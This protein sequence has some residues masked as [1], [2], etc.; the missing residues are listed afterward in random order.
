M[1]YADGLAKVLDSV[2]IEYVYHKHTSNC[3]SSCTVVKTVGGIVQDSNLDGSLNPAYGQRVTET[4]ASCGLGTQTYT[5]GWT[6]GGSGG[7]LPTGTTTYSHTYN[8]CGKNENT[9]ESATISFLQ[10]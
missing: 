4:H 6:V 8:R 3:N 10:K 9:I 2:N 1:G 7:A 5:N